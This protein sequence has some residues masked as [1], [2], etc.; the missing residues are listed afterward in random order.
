MPR[1][2]ALG[3]CEHH[4]AAIAHKLRQRR[5]ICLS[6]L[7][8]PG[9]GAAKGCLE[10]AQQA[11][12]RRRLTMKVRTIAFSVRALALGALLAGSPLSSAAEAPGNKATAKDI[13]REA[14]ETGQ[15]IKNYTVA[16]RD[17]AVKKAKAALDDLD[18]RVGR[19][20]RKLDGE[21]DRMDQAARRKARATLNALRRERNEVAEWYGGLKHGSAESW[22]QVKAGFLKS[23]QALKE[24][25]AKARKR[26]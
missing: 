3:R 15:A 18:G 1:M 7:L 24:S 26:L 8:Y 14:D 13:A 20:E 11:V 17:E 2:Q 10:G 6:G 22:E 19:M 21:W 23:Y 16:Q 12:F 9:H 4:A 5:S 25:F